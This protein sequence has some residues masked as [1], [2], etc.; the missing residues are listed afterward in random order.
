MA[1]IELLKQMITECQSDVNC[2]LSGNK[3]DY[4]YCKERSETYITK[5]I[6]KNSLSLLTAFLLKTAF[7]PLDILAKSVM[8]ASL[9]ICLKNSV[10]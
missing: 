4:L 1:Y 7:M 10:I 8:H 6:V 3:Q 5:I 2:F 9:W